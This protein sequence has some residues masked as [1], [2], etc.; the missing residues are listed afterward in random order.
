M[1]GPEDVRRRLLAAVDERMLAAQ[2]RTDDSRR[3]VLDGMHR[4]REAIARAPAGADPVPWLAALIADLELLRPR[5]EEAERDD[6]D[7]WLLGGMRTVIE[8][9][10]AEHDRLAAPPPAPRAWR[11][12]RWAGIAVAFAVLAYVVVIIVRDGWFDR[13]RHQEWRQDDPDLR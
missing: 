12:L 1:N 10:R 6:P 4:C 8:L 2:R 13:G 3:A 9:V 5:G 11:L 7:G